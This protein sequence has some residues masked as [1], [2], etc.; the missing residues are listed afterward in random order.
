MLIEIFG[1]Y[2]QF[3]PLYDIDIRPRRYILSKQYQTGK[4]SQKGNMELMQNLWI[5]EDQRLLERIKEDIVIGSTLIRTDLSR[6][7]YIKMDWY[8][9][10]MGEVIMQENE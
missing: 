5:P 4:P 9:D 1:F 6:R 8:K 3:L 7:F 2:I 10:E